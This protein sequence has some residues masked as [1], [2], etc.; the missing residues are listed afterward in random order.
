MLPAASRK[1]FISSTTRV[2]LCRQFTYH[3][4]NA[5]IR[6][7]SPQLELRNIGGFGIVYQGIIDDERVTIRQLVSDSDQSTSEFLVEVEI[8]DKLQH[9]NIVRFIGY[10]KHDKHMFLVFE[11]MGEGSLRNKL[12]QYLPERFYYRNRL[13]WLTRLK[14]CIDVARALDYLDNE[15]SS[16][17]FVHGVVKSSEILLD[18]QWRAKITVVE[19]LFSTSSFTDGFRYRAPEYIATGHRYTKSDVY[20]FGMIMLEVL[21]GRPAVDLSFPNRQYLAAWAQ[22]YLDKGKLKNFIDPEL[23]GEVSQKCL[24]DY[25]KIVECCLH[26]DPRSRSTMAEVLVGLESILA[27][28]EKTDKRIP[29]MYKTISK[30]ISDMSLGKHISSSG[31]NSEEG[32]FRKAVK[33]LSSKSLKHKDHGN[34]SDIE[35]ISEASKEKNLKHNIAFSSDELNP[36]SDPNCEFIDREVLSTS[37][38]ESSHI[39]SNHLQ[40]ACILTRRKDFLH[41]MWFYPVKKEAEVSFGFLVGKFSSLNK[42][43]QMSLDSSTAGYYL[44]EIQTL[45]QDLEEY[46]ED[47]AF[48]MEAY[49]PEDLVQNRLGP[50]EFQTLVI[51]ANSE[52]FWSDVTE[53]HAKLI[54]SATDR[55]LRCIKDLKVQMLGIWGSGVEEVTATL[56][57]MPVLKNEFDMVLFVRIKRHSSIEDL[58]KDIEEEIDLWKK[59]SSGNPNKINVLD[60][61]LNCLLFVDCSDG[62]FDLHEHQ[63]RLSKWFQNVQIVVTSG[64]QLAF[65]QVELEIRVQDHRLPWNI[66]FKNVDIATMGEDSGIKQLAVSMVEKCD[67]HLLAIILLARALRGVVEIGVWELALQEL[68]SSSQSGVISDVMVRVLRFVWPRMKTISQKCI[69]Q[70][71]LQYTGAEFE[72]S[73]L[74]N[75]WTISG[76]VKSET[77]A[78]YAFEDLERLFL[79]ERVAEKFVRIRDET[80]VA[81]LGHFIPRTHGLY[82]KQDGSKS[83]TMPSI[84]EWDIREIHLTNNILSELPDNPK[85]PI[86]VYLFLHSNQDLMDVPIT[87]FDNMP[88]LQVLDL[89]STSLKSL[90][91]SISKLTTLRKLFVRNCDLMMELPPEIGSLKHLKVVDSEGTQLIYLPEQVG[92]LTKLECLKFSL[93]NFPD[94][95]KRSNQNVQIIPAAEL[96]KLV[97]LKELSICVDL[98]G[99]WWEN[100]MKLIINILPKLRNLESLRLHFPTTELFC[101]FIE[102]KSWEGLPIYQHLSNFKF[103]VG[104][105]QQ[106]LISCL[107][108]DLDKMFVK[109]PKCLKFT[110]TEGEIEVISSAMKQANALF[111]DRHWTIRSLSTFGL[112]EMKNLKFCLLVECS[113]MLEIVN[114]SYLE[115]FSQGPVLESLEYMSIHRMKSL[116]CIWNGPIHYGCLSNLKTL[117]IHACPELRTVFTQGLLGNLTHIEYLAIEDCPKISSLI[118]LESNYSTSTQSLPSLK[119]ISLLHL[120]ELV[121]IS[122]G[123]SIAPRLESLVV[124]DCPILEK[125][126]SMEVS[127]SVKE[128]KG[129]KEWWDGLKWCEPEWTSGQPE[130]LAGVFIP[131][132]TDD[133]IMDELVDAVNFLPCN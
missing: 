16:Q 21:C 14:I 105:L 61:F 62:F 58:T 116:S 84:E 32:Y 33:F 15:K 83:S 74:I 26:A 49:L 92:S 55:A 35:A 23:K 5:A 128:I 85:C 59:R 76:V 91:S 127:D 65:W 12:H 72:I 9:P 20:S 40:R 67:G 79:I 97:H 82:L 119:K 124:Y 80:R 29:K 104:H 36:P 42:Y 60:Q 108:F 3:E 96:S 130:Y 44:M 71:A 39:R 63:F 41:L 70:F 64:S 106:R 103:I 51:E 57:D 47:A 31:L 6:N 93:Y 113:E 52:S 117:V 24:N 100:E 120:P 133:D 13:S 89:S 10:C 46:L 81:L 95:Y 18:Y 77:E 123:T 50:V 110:S 121:T 7:L 94:K 122:N 69:I 86:L 75:C 132:G 102:Q 27:L 107:P 125:L 54:A 38:T 118:S 114:G 111:L 98:N 19:R 28:Q 34:I 22:Q 17:D 109:L 90:P 73:S 126:S 115:D 25:A 129:E 99:E 53:V 48:D 66:F 88:S 78:E 43:I 1:E 101:L 37:R 30:T 11:F 112:A 8:L 2:Q 4:I 56:I 131:L 87:F 45:L 68:V